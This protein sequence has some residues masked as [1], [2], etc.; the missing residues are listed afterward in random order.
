MDG[1]LF[2]LNVAIWFMVAYVAIYYFLARAVLA[3]INR[4]DPDYF[5]VADERGELPIGMRTSS[6]IWEMLFDSDLPGR[7]YGQF[8]RIGLYAARVML[9]CYIPVGAFVIYYAWP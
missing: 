5:D 6:A 7:G 2:N 9:A 3:R 8:V 4:V 1:P